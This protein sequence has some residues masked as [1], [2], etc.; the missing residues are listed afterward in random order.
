MQNIIEQFKN[1]ML[2]N[3]INPPETVIGDG[4]LH[5]FKI[6]GKLNGA[7]V[8]HT[9]GRA[10]GY[11]EDFKQGIKIR[12]KLAGDFKPLTDAEKKAF[13]IERQRQSEQRKI[14]EKTRHDNATQKAAHIWNKATPAINHPYLIKKA[15]QPYTTRIYKGALV[16]P[17]YA[18]NSELVS[19]QFI[20]DDGS[21]RMM[22]GGKAQGSC[23]Y[24]GNVTKITHDSIILICEGWATGASLY[25]TTGYVTVV[26]FSSGNLTAVAGHI[27]KQYPDNEIIVCGDNDES[28]VGQQAAINAALAI[29][30]SYVVPPDIGDFNDYSLSLQVVSDDSE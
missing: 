16:V 3:F 2:D 26:A 4:Q 15:V 7:Y 8:L 19:L 11:F 9:D 24:I 28:G 22:K 6:E 30:G 23:C 27:R 20:A 13:A 12:W 17:L 5:R 1:A 25:E 18:E 21:K 29:N 14:E 10:A